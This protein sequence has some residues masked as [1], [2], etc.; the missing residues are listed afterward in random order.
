MLDSH[1]P[2]RRRASLRQFREL[3]L[4]L[5]L[6]VIHLL[7][8][9]GEQRRDSVG[10]FR[11]LRALLLDFVD[12]RLV[13]AVRMDVVEGGRCLEVV[14]V[15]LI[16]VFTVGRA[17]AS[18]LRDTLDLLSVRQHA[19]TEQV[20]LARLLLLKELL[21]RVFCLRHRVHCFLDVLPSVNN[22][23]RAVNPDS[24]AAGAH[25]DLLWHQLLVVLG[26]GWLRRGRR[27]DDLVR[28]C[29]VL[30]RLREGAAGSLFDNLLLSVLKRCQNRS[31]RFLLLVPH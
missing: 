24:M 19:L 12:V 26:R 16:H 28:G 9:L 29:M 22:L 10:A 3:L 18:T 17:R 2:G 4:H 8:A 14:Q 30:L 27:L 6:L 25:V 5:S 1:G 20:L 11:R 7:L 23:G 31:H 15:D 13:L 21:F